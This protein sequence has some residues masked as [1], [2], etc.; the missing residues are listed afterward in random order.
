MPKFRNLIL[1]FLALLTPVMITTYVFISII[2][3][4]QRMN[5]KFKNVLGESVSIYETVL[6]DSE[7]RI[8]FM[9]EFFNN[10]ISYDIED[11]VVYFD[12]IKIEGR[13]REPYLSNL[14]EKYSYLWLNDNKNRLYISSKNTEKIEVLTDRYFSRNLNFKRNLNVERNFSVQGNFSAGASTLGSTT[15]LGPLNASAGNFTG[16][17]IS[18]LFSAGSSTLTS[19]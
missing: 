8:G 7:K 9:S 3:T 10:F 15:V 18:G 12:K 5:E 13:S 1:S 6:T 2:N 16:L 17:G 11:S 4:N 14:D 19:L